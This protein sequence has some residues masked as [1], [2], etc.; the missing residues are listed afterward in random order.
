MWLSLEDAVQIYA[1]ALLARHRKGAQRIVFD[2]ICQLRAGKDWEGIKVWEGVA[3]ELTR[4]R[5]SET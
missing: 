4:I 2:S 5:T 1:K 3:A